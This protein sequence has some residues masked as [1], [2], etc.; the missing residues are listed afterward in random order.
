MALVPSCGINNTFQVLSSPGHLQMPGDLTVPAAETQ[1][2]PMPAFSFSPSIALWKTCMS[3]M[4]AFTHR[5][6]QRAHLGLY[7][8][9]HTRLI[10]TDGGA[11]ANTL[12]A[13]SFAQLEVCTACD[14]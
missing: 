5:Q 7:A 14:E 11:D 4:P 13:V 6:G 10:I 8:L 12:C 1:E 2:C 9:T 3:H